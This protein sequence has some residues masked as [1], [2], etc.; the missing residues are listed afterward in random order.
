MALSMHEK[1][2]NV[3]GSDDEINEP[4]K[5]RLAK[6]GI[7]PKEIGWFPQKLSADMEAVILGMHARADNPELIRAPYNQYLYFF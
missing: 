1:G 7:L 4:S 5:T 6:A 2:F 3:T